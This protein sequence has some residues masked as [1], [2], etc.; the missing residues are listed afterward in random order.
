MK[1][2]KF[3]ENFFT[4][5]THKNFLSNGDNNYLISKCVLP[6]NKELADGGRYHHHIKDYTEMQNNDDIG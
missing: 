4:K 1:L 5:K 6:K 3:C 2:K